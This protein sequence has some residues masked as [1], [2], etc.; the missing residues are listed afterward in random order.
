MYDWVVQLYEFRVHSMGYRTWYADQT[1][2]F[3]TNWRAEGTWGFEYITLTPTLASGWDDDDTSLDPA[4][5]QVNGASDLA[6]T[7]VWKTEEIPFQRGYPVL[8]FTRIMESGGAPSELVIVAMV[9]SLEPG[10]VVLRPGTDPSLE[11]TNLK[12]AHIRLDKFLQVETVEVASSGPDFVIFSDQFVG[13]EA[14]QTGVGF[15]RDEAATIALRRTTLLNLIRDNDVRFR[16]IY[17]DG[18]N[19]VITWDEFQR[20][21]EYFAWMTG[22]DMHSLPLFFGHDPLTDETDPLESDILVWDEEDPYWG[23][24]IGYVGRMFENDTHVVRVTPRLPVFEFEGFRETNPVVRLGPNVQIDERVALPSDIRAITGLLEGLNSRWQVWGDYA[25][26]GSPNR[27]RAI[28]LVAAMFPAV[29]GEVPLWPGDASDAWGR[30]VL[31]SNWPLTVEWVDGAQTEEDEGTILIDVMGSRA[32]ASTNQ[33][34][35]QTGFNIVIPGNVDSD[36]MP[37]LNTGTAANQWNNSSIN[38]PATNNWRVVAVSWDQ[39]NGE[40][41][42]GT[43]RVATVT[44]RAESSPANNYIFSATHPDGNGITQ[45]DGTLAAI[46]VTVNTTES[47]I[48]VPN[49]VRVISNTFREIRVRFLV[50]VIDT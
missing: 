33:V 14:L 17:E 35:I 34:P 12:E 31:L 48:L 2:E 6:N 22:R 46:G 21:R 15:D 13:V 38:D 39:R 36:E 20:N 19:R 45:S 30:G 7:R 26:E 24:T 3:V 42:D 27:Q 41:V 9:G 29:G 8:D 18:E 44:L 1:P 10:T 4:T 28:P 16:V 11:P 40:F 49:S 25:R 43:T 32:P 23:F 50:D 47:S 37:I 5:T